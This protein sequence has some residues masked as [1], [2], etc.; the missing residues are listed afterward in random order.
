[1]QFLKKYRGSKILK[2]DGWK[3][4]LAL[5]S[6]EILLTSQKQYLTYW[7]HTF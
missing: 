4:P 6:L 2:R 7:S 3:I 1:M 5:H